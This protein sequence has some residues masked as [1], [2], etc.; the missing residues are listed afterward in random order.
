MCCTAEWD[1]SSAEEA[2]LGYGQLFGAP[3][4][5]LLPLRAGIAFGAGA[6]Y[7]LSSHYYFF[8]LD[9]IKEMHL[10]IPHVLLMLE[11]RRFENQLLP[12]VVLIKL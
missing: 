4:L 3:A 12:C 1:P 2:E 9:E 7:L 10:R 8:S 6:C 5:D 11:T